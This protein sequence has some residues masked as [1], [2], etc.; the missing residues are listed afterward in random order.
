VL[1]DGRDG[2]D[3]AL[4]E[5]VGAALLA[6]ESTGALFVSECALGFE[7]L[8]LVPELRGMDPKQPAEPR[9]GRT[10]VVADAADQ[11]LAQRGEIRRSRG[12]GRRAA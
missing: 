6:S 12:R 2:R 8:E 1:D 11:L 3:L 9:G 7:L 10:G 4:P 5:E